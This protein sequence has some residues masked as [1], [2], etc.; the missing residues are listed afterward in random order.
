MEFI[1]KINAA[2]NGIVW[3]PV[4]LTLLIG[5]GLF[6]SAKMGFLQFRKL[7][8]AMKNTIGSVFSK[9]QHTKDESGVSPFQAVATAMAGTI[10]TG[11]IAGIATAIVSGGPGAVFWM[12]ISAL[13]GMITK[14]SEIVLS[15]KF[16]EKNPA[17]QW[18]GGPMYYIKN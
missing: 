11:S 3:G 15:L 13:L 1:S 5:A 17:G 16:R 18:T 14:Y 7:G 8:Y 10:G 4:M 6:L 12:W 9:N 2:V